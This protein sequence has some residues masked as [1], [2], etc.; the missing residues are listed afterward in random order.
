MKSADLRGVSVPRHN[1]RSWS[2]W[3][4]ELSCVLNSLLLSLGPVVVSHQ[5]ASLFSSREEV[6][7]CDELELQSD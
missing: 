7:E 1:G 4:E 2:K 3:T 6:Q 5:T